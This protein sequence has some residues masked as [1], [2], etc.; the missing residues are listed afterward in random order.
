MLPLTNF[1]IYIGVCSQLY[2]L[3]EADVVYHYIIRWSYS[4]MCY[5]G[6]IRNPIIT[7]NKKYCC[8]RQQNVQRFLVVIITGNGDFKS[9]FGLFLR[10]FSI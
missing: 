9:H 8:R 7:I 1:I 2:T 6:N 3:L 10:D 4:Y 5:Y